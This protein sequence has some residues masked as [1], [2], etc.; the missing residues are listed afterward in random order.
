MSEAR[1]GTH[2]VIVTLPEIYDQVQKT[3][4]KVDLLTNQIGE[5]V[6]VNRRL[7]SHSQSIADHDGRLDKLEIV[8][9]VLQ[10]QQKPSTPW[11]SIV[12]AVAAILSSV[13]TVGALLVMG[14]KIAA[15][16]S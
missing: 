7:D 8:Q 11:P 2:G 5:L 15:A 6:A 14:S 4:D 13:V 12:T 3:D 16:L 10:A 9:A 1:T